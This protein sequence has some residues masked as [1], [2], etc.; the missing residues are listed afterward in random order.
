MVSGDT[1]V[2]LLARSRN[3]LVGADSGEYQTVARDGVRLEVAVNS[4]Q[5]TFLGNTSSPKISGLPQVLSD[6]ILRSI[7]AISGPRLTLAT[8][9]R[10][11][12]ISP[13]DEF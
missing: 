1:A 4:F 3:S 10:S 5:N 6:R 12:L 8:V 13:A 11:P 9:Y 7:A 2:S